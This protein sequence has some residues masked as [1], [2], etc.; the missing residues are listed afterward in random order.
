MAEHPS[1]GRYVTS[2]FYE[3]D[4]LRPHQTPQDDR[5]RWEESIVVS[6]DAGSLEEFQ[7]P[8]FALACD[9][10]PKKYIRKPLAAASNRH[11]QSTK[12]E[13]QQAYEKYRSYRTE[14]G[15]MIDSV[16]YE[17]A[18]ARAM[19]QLPHLKSI[20]VSCGR[21]LTNHFCA[22]FK[23]G[24]SED[25]GS[26]RGNAAETIGAHQLSFILSAADKTGLEIT[27]LVCGSL[28]QIFLD[29][30]FE[31]LDAMK[32][33][34]HGLRSLHLFLSHNTEETHY[35]SNPNGSDSTGTRSMSFASFAP[36]LEILSVRFDEDRPADPPDLE[37]LVKEFHWSSLASA[38]FAK[39]NTSSENL[40][41]FCGRH[42][43]TLKD[44][45]LTDIRLCSGGW[46][47]TFYKMR[48]KL[49]LKNMTV[50]GIFQS[51]EGDYWDFELGNG[52]HSKRQ[53]IERYIL[54][55]D[56]LKRDLPYNM[57]A[58]QYML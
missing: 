13:L 26:D 19:K 51:D 28:G 15:R 57:F 9:R 25:V 16:A 1:A 22:A 33:S 2:L 31:R 55:S 34:I 48:Q 17:E 23:A 49:E 14:Q 5:E 40:I 20:I 24:L 44:F 8:C 38:S 30:S 53:M 52:I 10:L 35:G 32:R 7:D 45:S 6:D 54:H 50:A 11:L 47:L 21:G 12:R 39:M 58:I 56:P 46:L 3:A 41:G 29:Y 37:N 27:K 43:G 36:N 4:I 18:L 42:A